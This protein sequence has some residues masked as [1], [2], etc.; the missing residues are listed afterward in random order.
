VT[1][2]YVCASLTFGSYIAIFEMISIPV[3]GV[4]VRPANFVA[5]IFPMFA[6]FVNGPVISVS[7]V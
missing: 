6:I 5:D 1:D 7:T 4:V 2:L 3:P